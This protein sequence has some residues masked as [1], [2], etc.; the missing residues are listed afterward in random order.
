MASPR[1]DLSAILHG[2]CDNV[3]FQPPT[4][5]ELAYPCFVYNLEQIDTR[6]ADNAA[7]T[8]ND[9]YLVT[10]ITRDPDNDVKNQMAKLPLCSAN[11]FFINDNL[12]HYPFTIYL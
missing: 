6:R 10:Y 9:R 12:Y 3:Y 2:M 11:R 7:Y 1:S 8:L 5:K 4:G